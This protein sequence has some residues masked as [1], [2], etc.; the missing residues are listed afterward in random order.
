MAGERF[1]NQGTCVS[2]GP[3]TSGA[4]FKRDVPNDPFDLAERTVLVVP[5]WVVR[6]DRPMWAGR[7]PVNT[8][9]EDTTSV[10]QSRG[11]VYRPNE[12][13]QSESVR[14]G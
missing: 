13:G 2:T 8:R 4:S 6:P 10:V 14:P 1:G 11:R 5:N 3:L 12:P 7:T 9:A